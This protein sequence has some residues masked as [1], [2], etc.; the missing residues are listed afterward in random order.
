MVDTGYRDAKK[1][2][3]LTNPDVSLAFY[4]TDIQN[5]KHPFNKDTELA[6]SNW[7]KPC[8]ND[9]NLGIPIPPNQLFW[10]ELLALISKLYISQITCAG[11]ISSRKKMNDLQIK[12]IFYLYYVE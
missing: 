2:K 4:I 11:I 1:K 3:R 7:M 8:M 6:G 9:H 5:I 12:Y 10:Q